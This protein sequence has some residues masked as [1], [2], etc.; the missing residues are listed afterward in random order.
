MKLVIPKGA[1]SR[2]VTVFIRDSSSTTG[3]GLGS[4]TNAS[5]IVGG[6]VREGST[7][8][9]LAV[10]EDVT[11]EGT[12]QA[13][14]AQG[15]VRIGTPANMR[16]GTYELHFHNNLWA[17]GAETVTITLGGATNMAPLNI[18]VQLSDPV[19]GLGAPTALPNAAA[20]AA[21]GLPISDA[22]GLD[23]D[24]QIGT[25][26][27][28]LV[29]RL[30]TP[31]NLGGGATVAANL[32][33]IESQTDD[34]GVAGAGLTDLGGMSTTMKGQV[35][36]EAEDALAAVGVTTTVTGRIDA[37]ISTRFASS[38]APSNFSS[39]GINA[40]GHISRVTLV[41]TTTTNTDML[42][43]ANV[44]SA[45]GL[46]SANL[47]TQLDA[48]PTAAENATAVLT[49]AMTEAYATDGSTATLA[50]IN[51]MI[52]S[53]VCQFDISG[54]T[55]TLRKLDGST[56]AMTVTLND[57]ENPTSRTRAS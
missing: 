42:T 55:M 57:S 51:Y 40:S 28:N 11:T 36:T 2:I 16:T 43:Q 25:D 20:D 1:T 31:S 48:L 22:G 47:D 4:L 33:D 27:D 45:V 24:A 8:V 7:G 10:D 6:F 14:S 38:A 19:R 44:R 53:A 23:L 29:S 18:E 17:T 39:L 37:A 32:A 30:G 3:A 9:A 21:G 35:Q 15:K 5:S 49:T 41:D 12:Y 34:I 46:A 56:S 50:Q 26:I 52:W 13:P 54:T